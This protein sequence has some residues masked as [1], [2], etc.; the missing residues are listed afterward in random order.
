[1]YLVMRE[2]RCA[3]LDLTQ[4]VPIAVYF[5]QSAAEQHAQAVQTAA[6]QTLDE[7]TSYRQSPAPRVILALDPT[8]PLHDD[9]S[10]GYSVE[11]IPLISQPLGDEGLHPWLATLL[12]PAPCC[13]P[14]GM[15]TA[16]GAAFSRLRKGAAPGA[17]A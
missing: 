15:E 13:Q 9:T 1:M 5:D 7:L 2:R 11:T 12:N 10:V 8:C 17:S 3:M 14:D 6:A 4:V 16:M